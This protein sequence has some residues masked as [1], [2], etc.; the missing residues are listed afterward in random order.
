MEAICVFVVL[1]VST[2]NNL[3]GPAALAFYTH[4]HTHGH[5]YSMH[6]CST[7]ANYF[8]VKRVC[9]VHLILNLNLNIELNIIPT[10]IIH[11]ILTYVYFVMQYHF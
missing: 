3:A 5:T 8:D 11:V 7:L 2:V 4:T 6:Y 10:L 1:L 9:C